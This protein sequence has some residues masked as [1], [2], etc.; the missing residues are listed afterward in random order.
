M[1][2]S[3]GWGKRERE[4]R[5]GILPPFVPFSSLSSLTRLL[6][7]MMIM[8]A[9]LLLQSCLRAKQDQRQKV[10]SPHV[11]S[12]PGSLAHRETRVRGTDRKLGS[13]V[14]LSP[15]ILG[16][17]LDGK[18][19]IVGGRS[20]VV[21]LALTGQVTGWLDGMSSRVAVHMTVAAVIWTL[22]R[23]RTQVECD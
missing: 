12:P 3:A 6:I 5:Q 11:R 16:R 14:S 4:Q 21:W 1:R 19:T 20:R 10:I 18:G 22:E 9:D 23:L 13:Q 7:M 17:R 2:N 8:S 15:R